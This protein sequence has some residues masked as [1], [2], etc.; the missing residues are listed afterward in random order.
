MLPTEILGKARVVHWVLA[1]AV[2]LLLDYGTG[3]FIQFPILFVV[4]VAL[5]TVTHGR[6]GGIAIAMVLPLLRLTFFL[7]WPLP[8]SW[9][10]EAIDTLVDM[11]ILVGL[12]FLIDNVLQQQR[13]IRVLQGLLPICA[14]CKK[15]RDES[16]QWRQLETFITERSAARFSHTFC[17]ECGRR[18]YPDIVD[19]PK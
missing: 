5:A 15:I 10:L 3:P 6:A 9:Q 7:M 18:H 14:F 17:Q 4:P 16:G 19:Q 12:S 13:A 2:I 11:T 1:S 8:S